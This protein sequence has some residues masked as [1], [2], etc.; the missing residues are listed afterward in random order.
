MRS[1]LRTILTWLLLVIP[2]AIA[3]SST[4]TEVIFFG[5]HGASEKDIQSW[6]AKASQAEPYK[7]YFNFR[8]KHFLG[9]R[10]DR[11]TSMSQNQEA[12]NELI[13]EINN[14]PADKKYILVGHSSGS[15]STFKIAAGIDESRR[16]QI[17]VVNLDGF[18]PREVPRGVAT[19]CW[20]ARD[21]RTRVGTE[22]SENME[23]CRDSQVMLAHDC[24]S[25]EKCLHNSLVN[26]LSPQAGPHGYYKSI[27]PNLSW[28][29]MP[30]AGATAEAPEAVR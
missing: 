21:I 1:Q 5:G 10:W 17:H 7:N 22:N 15:A 2:A 18:S 24:K 25:N 4:K 19:T 30:A 28:L 14:S 20:T 8:G 11:K 9:K 29:K 12:V 6:V 23:R 13:S 16:S 3:Q 26:L 27:S